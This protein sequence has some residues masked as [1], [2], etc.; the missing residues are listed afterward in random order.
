MNFFQ[1]LALGNVETAVV[2][3][4]KS[5]AGVEAGVYVFKL[6]LH[7]NF[8]P[9]IQMFDFEGLK[10]ILRMISTFWQMHA[11]LDIIG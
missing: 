5:K 1:T 11:S 6:T 3:I 8:T 7:L 9:F 10:A 4:F 2:L